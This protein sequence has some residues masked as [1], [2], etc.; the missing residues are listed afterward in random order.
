[1][2][3]LVLRM[4][5]QAKEER[6]NVYVVLQGELAMTSCRTFKE[7]VGKVVVP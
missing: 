2:Q 4:H 1:M 3:R 5:C 6:Q 7:L